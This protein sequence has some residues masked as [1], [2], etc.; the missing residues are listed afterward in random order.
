MAAQEVM[1]KSR[2]GIEG[3]VFAVDLLPM[4]PIPGVDFIQGDLGSPEVQQKLMRLLDHDD[5]SSIS[6]LEVKPSIHV[7]LSDMAPSMTG[8][9]WEEGRERDGYASS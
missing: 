1:A 6:P 4:H 3:R 9:A 5:S 7:V 2:V 8:E